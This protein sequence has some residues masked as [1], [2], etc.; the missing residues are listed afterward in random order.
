MYGHDKKEGFSY[1]EN[2]VYILLF[3]RSIN[4]TIYQLLKINVSV[5]C[6]SIVPVGTNKSLFGFHGNGKTFLGK[7]DLVIPSEPQLTCFT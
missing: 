1:L 7:S 4:T 2:F 3:S 6:L 5:I